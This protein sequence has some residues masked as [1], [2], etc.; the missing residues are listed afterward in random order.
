MIWKLR[1]VDPDLSRIFLN[2]IEVLQKFVDNSIQMARE[3]EREQA[4]AEEEALRQA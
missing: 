3:K 4:K 2:W 1:V